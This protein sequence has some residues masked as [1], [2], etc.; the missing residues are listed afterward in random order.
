[1]RAP[2]TANP[3]NLS[4]GLMATKMDKG[5]TFVRRVMTPKIMRTRRFLKEQTVRRR[6]MMLTLLCLTE[7]GQPKYIHLQLLRKKCS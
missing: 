7:A 5:S 3:G 6:V 4:W 1:M 2:K